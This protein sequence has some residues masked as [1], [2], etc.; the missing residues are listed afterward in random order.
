MWRCPAADRFSYIMFG[1]YKNCEHDEEVHCVSPIK[2]VTETV[3]SSNTWVTKVTEKREQFIHVCPDEL[4][5]Q[6]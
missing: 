2:S 5:V 4:E 1:G 6:L 3:S